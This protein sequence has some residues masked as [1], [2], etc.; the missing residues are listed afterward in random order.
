[1]SVRLK[2]EPTKSATGGTRC[3]VNTTKEDIS[4]GKFCYNDR[5]RL[6]RIEEKNNKKNK[7]HLDKLIKKIKK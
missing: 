5:Q 2:R 1:M 7:Q 3:K 6:L 4:I